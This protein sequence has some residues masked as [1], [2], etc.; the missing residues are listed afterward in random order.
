MATSGRAGG[1]AAWNTFKA[2]D[3]E[4]PVP[5]VRLTPG[6]GR[7]QG[8]GDD[9]HDRVRVLVQDNAVLGDGHVDPV[10]AGAKVHHDGLAVEHSLG[11]DRDEGEPVPG[12]GERLAK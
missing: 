6:E 9:L 3:S 10:V 12:I 8:P 7:L 11:G 5:L 1:S 2:D 4:A